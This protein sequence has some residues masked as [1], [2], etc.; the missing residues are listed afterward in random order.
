MI[1]SYIFMP[2][3]TIL[4]SFLKKII[5]LISWLSPSMFCWIHEKK[6]KTKTPVCLIEYY[7]QAAVVPRLGTREIFCDMLCYIVKI[8]NLLWSKGNF[9]LQLE[10]QE[11]YVIH[12][13]KK[14]TLAAFLRTHC[15]WWVEDIAE[16][17]TLDSIVF[18][19]IQRGM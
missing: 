1:Q 17:K 8:W 5:S 15:L 9:S 10:E 16:M 3:N 2:K 12:V 11:P 14:N 13:I 6:V 18:F 4:P 7:L 19:N